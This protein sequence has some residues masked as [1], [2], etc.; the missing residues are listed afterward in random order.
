MLHDKSSNKER[1]NVTQELL[2]LTNKVVSRMMLS[3]RS[4]GSDG[5]AEEARTLIREVTLLFGEFNFSDFIWFLK[6]VDFQGFRRRFE[7]IHTRYDTLLEGIISDREESRKKKQLNRS[8][9]EADDLKDFLDMMLDVAEDD[10]SEM[11]LTRNHIKA[12]V[13]L[14]F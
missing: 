4:S 9:P 8:S 2:K 3:I 5:Q 6:N 10:F 13:L 12:L 1:V 7:D 14:Q 11:K